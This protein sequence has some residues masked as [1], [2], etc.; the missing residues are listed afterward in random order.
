MAQQNEP[1][2]SGSLYDILLAQYD[3]LLMQF[4]ARSVLAA[5]LEQK[6]KLLSA[7]DQERQAALVDAER[8]AAAAESELHSLSHDLA[9]CRAE[10]DTLLNSRSWR[11]TA[12][13]RALGKMIKGG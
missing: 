4:D 8:R 6:V 10:L 1:A 5:E 11:L 2:N 12:P 9:V 3:S 7:G 13:L